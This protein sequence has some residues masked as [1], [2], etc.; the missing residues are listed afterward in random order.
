MLERIGGQVGVAG[1]GRGLGVS[2][3]RPDNR[4][5]QAARGP[6]TGEAVPEVVQAHVLKP[7]G[8][9]YAVPRLA[10]VDQRLVGVAAGNYPR[11]AVPPLNAIQD[12]KGRGV[13]VNDL[14][15]GLALGEP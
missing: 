2:K 8:L 5:G 15:A 7:G 11:R 4:Q 9:A 13:Q 3:Q 14:G 6:D 1:R 12:L 10:E